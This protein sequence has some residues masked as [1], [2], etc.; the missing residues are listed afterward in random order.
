MGQSLACL[1]FRFTNARRRIIQPMLDAKKTSDAVENL[2]KCTSPQRSI[3]SEP[4]PDPRELQ[5]KSSKLPLAAWQT[6]P[7]PYC[8]SDFLS[9]NPVVKKKLQKY[10]GT[11]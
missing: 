9:L 1:L 2:A 4:D 10:K 7:Y 11:D 6:I 8:K 3:K 5:L